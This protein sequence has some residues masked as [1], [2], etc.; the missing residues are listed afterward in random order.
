MVE[1]KQQV[2]IRLAALGTKR[3]LI[4][5]TVSPEPTGFGYFPYL[6]FR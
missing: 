1:R 5:V 4:E 3:S 2:G 6:S